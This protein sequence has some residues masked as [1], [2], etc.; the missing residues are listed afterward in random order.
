MN[1]C[2]ALLL[3]YPWKDLDIN[4]LNHKMIQVSQTLQSF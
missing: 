1:F 4:P 2:F 3:N